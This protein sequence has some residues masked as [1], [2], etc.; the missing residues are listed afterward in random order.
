MGLDMGIFINRKALLGVLAIIVLIF[1][2]L[3]LLQ[4]KE[5]FPVKSIS[6]GEAIEKLKNSKEDVVL[7]TTVNDKNWYLTLKDNMKGQEKFI[8]KM[9][10]QG[11]KFEM[12]EGSGFFFSKGNEELIAGCKIWN[13]D[14]LVCHD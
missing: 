9:E 8:N 6:P 7:I 10:S 3:Y 13:S 4:P 11:W 2:A 14:Y 12:Q 5:P 1:A